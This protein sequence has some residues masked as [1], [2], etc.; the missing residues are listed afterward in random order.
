MNLGGIKILNNKIILLM[1]FLIMVVACSGCTS[2]E[3]NFENSI[4]S[5]NIPENWTVVDV[6]STD[7]LASLKPTEINKT[8]I[9]ITSTDV[10]PQQVIDGYLNNYPSKYTRFQVIKNEP[11]TVDGVNGI[12]LVFKNTAR[13]DSLQRGPDYLSSIV[14]FSKNNQT[15][16]I[17]SDEVSENEYQSNVESA[18]KKLVSSIKIK[19]YLNG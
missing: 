13:N 1:V 2:L 6:S 10:S 18:M 16:I 14:T 15:Y 9:S 4:L 3:D 17:S 11:V 8:L 5:F 12:I 7:T 19:G